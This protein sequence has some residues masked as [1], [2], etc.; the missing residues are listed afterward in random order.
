MV[1]N[2]RPRRGQ[3]V[4]DEKDGLRIVGDD[5]LNRWA[6]ATRIGLEGG[7]WM[8]NYHVIE[9]IQSGANISDRHFRGFFQVLHGNGKVKWVGHT[10]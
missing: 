9:A 3:I 1:R 4:G 7:F 6:R 10:M 2:D 8:S 5:F